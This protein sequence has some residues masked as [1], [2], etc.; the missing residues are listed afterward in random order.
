MASVRKRKW[1]HNGESR[2]AWVV[3][4][5]DGKGKRRIKTFDKK[6]AADTFRSE[7]ETGQHID[8]QLTAKVMTFGA[9]LDAWLIEIDRRKHIGEISGNYHFSMQNMVK[10][11]VRSHLGAMKLHALT[12]DHVQ[13]WLD[14]RILSFSKETVKHALIPV[15]GALRLALRKKWIARNPL[16]DD[17]IK[18]ADKPKAPRVIPDKLQIAQ[19]LQFIANRRPHQS[20]KSFQRVLL[21]FTLG[22][23]QG[24]RIGEVC[25]LQWDDVDMEQGVIRIKHSLSRFDGLKAPK[26]AAGIRTLPIS[27]P[28]FTMLLMLKA[29]HRYGECKGHVYRTND[30]RPVKPDEARRNTFYKVMFAAGL[31]TSRTRPLFNLHSLR[32]AALS[33][34]AEKGIPPLHLKRIAGHK[35]IQTTMDIYG[36]LFPGDDA[37]ARI[38]GSVAAQFALPAP[39]PTRQGCDIAT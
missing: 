31:S 38:M 12:R 15:H 14:E 5:T 7:V 23:F 24:L 1:D 32:H 17:P 36:H 8:N 2:E 16:V 19:L 9:A 39:A 11:H 6:K 27:P 29:S 25:G 10:R 26:T 13:E 3:D 37:D 35:S 21:I 33:L 30:G 22:L 34:L 20:E 28:T 18:V 4:Y